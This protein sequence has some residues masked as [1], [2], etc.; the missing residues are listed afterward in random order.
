MNPD[1]WVGRPGF[2]RVCWF[3]ERSCPAIQK[4]LFIKALLV[5]LGDMPVAEGQ[6]HHV[7]KENGYLKVIYVLA[8]HPTPV[9]GHPTPIVLLVLAFYFFCV[10]R[11]VC[12]ATFRVV[13]VCFPS[14]GRQNPGPN[15]SQT[16]TSTYAQR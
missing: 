8:G 9:G 15:R 5:P 4:E 3:G 2:P 1:L 16:K 7:H 12:L 6:K 11:V 10:F 13:C 14:A